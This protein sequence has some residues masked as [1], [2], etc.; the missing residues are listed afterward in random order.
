MATVVDGTVAVKAEEELRDQRAKFPRRA[1]ASSINAT[2][3]LRTIVRRRIHV[4]GS[5]IRT[6]PNRIDKSRLTTLMHV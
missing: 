6:H 2:A 1:V 5:S 4:R 3:N